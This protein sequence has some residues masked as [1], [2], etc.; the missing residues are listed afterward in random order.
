MVS[1]TFLP[2]HIPQ[3]FLSHLLRHMTTEKRT[4]RR[5]NNKFKCTTRKE[6]IDQTSYSGIAIFR[7]STENES[8]FDKFGSSRRKSGV[9]QCAVFD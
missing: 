9:K 6:K 7:T 1:L 8:L 5:K 4:K 3:S 2:V